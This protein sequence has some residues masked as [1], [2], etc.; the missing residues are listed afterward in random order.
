MNVTKEM[1]NAATATLVEANKSRKLPRHEAAHQLLEALVTAA[2]PACLRVER[3][4]G[5]GIESC[6]ISMQFAGVCGR[7]RVIVVLYVYKG[8]VWQI[9]KSPVLEWC[10]ENTEFIPFHFVYETKDG[11]AQW[12][13]HS[14]PGFDFLI[15][16]IANIVKDQS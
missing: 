9:G 5:F 13:H 2:K 1:I 16:K 14:T 10:A 4:I 3:C 8:D 6:W 11:E 7:P 12:L 15:D